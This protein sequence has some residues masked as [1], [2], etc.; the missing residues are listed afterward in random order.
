MANTQIAGRAAIH[1]VDG[2]IIYGI[3]TEA[4]DNGFLNSANMTDA[5][6]VSELRDGQNNVRSLA[7]TNHHQ[8]ASFSF[9]P[10]AKTGTNTLVEAAKALRYPTPLALVEIKNLGDSGAT[11]SATDNDGLN[12]KWN[13]MGGDLSFTSNDFVKMTLNCRR[14]IVDGDSDTAGVALGTFAVAD[15]DSSTAG[16]DQGKVVDETLTD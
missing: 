12:G 11:P 1:G 13:Y 8:T 4:D 14:Q 16:V 6:D 5:F 2:V 7:S 3:I 15:Q 9:T 10:T